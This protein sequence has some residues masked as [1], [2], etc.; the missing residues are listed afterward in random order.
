MRGLI[1]ILLLIA[2]LFVLYQPAFAGK[3]AT[4]VQLMEKINLNLGRFLSGTDNQVRFGAPVKW[5]WGRAKLTH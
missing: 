1:H 3:K 5:K 4:A 2:A